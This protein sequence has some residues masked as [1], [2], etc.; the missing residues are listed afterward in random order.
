MIAVIR[1]EKGW[2]QGVKFFNRGFSEILLIPDE[3]VP[4]VLA[5]A[6]TLIL[7]ARLSLPNICLA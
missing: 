7:R 2:E 4:D 6:R 3:T 5:I 1:G